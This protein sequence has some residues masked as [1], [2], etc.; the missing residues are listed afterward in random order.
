MGMPSQRPY[1]ILYLDTAPSAGGS[2]VSL[3]ELVRSLDRTRY[4]PIVVTYASHAY[5]DRF[6]SLGIE[7]ISCDLYGRGDH[8][9]GWVKQVRD[10]PTMRLLQR[11]PRGA[12]LLH[13][14]GFVLLLIRVVWPRTRL[15]RNIIRQHAV[16]LVHTNIRIGHDR[17]GILAAWLAG[18][19][20]VAHIRDFEKLNC[21]DRW[22][23]GRTSA[24]VYISKAIQNAHL[25]SGVAVERG[26]VVYNGVDDA[27]FAAS[28][29]A[30]EQRGKLGIGA[31]DLVAGVIG[32]LERWKGQEVFLRAMKLVT[33]ALPRARGVIIGDPVPYDLDYQGWLVA[34]REELGL[35]SQVIFAPFQIDVSAT[36][37]ALDVL[38]L[39]SISP[40]PFG[41]VLIEGMAAGRPIVATEGGATPEIVRPGIDG[42]LV[43][44]DDPQALADAI[45]QI[46]QDPQAGKRM[47]SRGRERVCDDFGL[48]RHVARIQAIYSAIL[49]KQ[50]IGQ[51][52]CDVR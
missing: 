4:E 33:A 19:P 7:V 32:R 29:G 26:I 31:E 21:F 46:L 44:P 18:I 34:L 5:I 47:G 41:R 35:V 37:A 24:L 30:S 10:S 20:C 16:D 36:M 14:L 45:V 13:L 12:D 11:F 39:P 52:A 48:P 17:E 51:P 43:Q 15:L 3:Y 27:A 8:R 50:R 1:R 49:N 28:S 6:R 23:V 2:V 9:P 42:V 40:E 22:L 25:A 38:V